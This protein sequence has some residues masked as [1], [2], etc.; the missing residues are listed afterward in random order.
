MI[1]L[2]NASTIIS[3]PIE[4]DKSF[5]PIILTLW[6]HNY[7]RL[8]IVMKIFMRSHFSVWKSFDSREGRGV[9]LGDGNFEELLIALNAR[10][11]GNSIVTANE[12]VSVSFELL[13][14]LSI[15][16]PMWEKEFES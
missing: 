7:L 13:V 16:P 14:I 8:V 11:G 12:H 1:N 5:S 2:Q 3:E 15:N 9:S 6:Y 4:N 10:H